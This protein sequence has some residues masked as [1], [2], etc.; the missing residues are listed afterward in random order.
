MVLSDNKIRELAKESKLLVPFDE[1]K[2]QG[3]SYDISSGPVAIIF[4][5]VKDV[6]DLHNNQS[7]E[8]IHHEVDITNGYNVKPNEYLLIKT[9]E[10]FSI[11]FNMTAHIRPRTTF[12]KI[13]LIVSAQ[14]MNPNFKGYLYLGLYNATHNTIKIS[15]DLTIAQMVFEE[16]YGDITEKKLY[17]NKADAKYQDEDEFITPKYDNLNDDDKATV[18][19][20]INNML[21]RC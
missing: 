5:S 3:V 6:I 15:S 21:G 10:K 17:N 8:R 7:I 4:Q 12:T 16:V 18:D 14:H 2:L 9:K 20:I 13:G 19:G 1:N 11:P